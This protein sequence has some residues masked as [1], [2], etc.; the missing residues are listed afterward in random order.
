M[1]GQFKV[2][3]RVRALTDA[4]VPE[5]LWCEPDPTA[6]GSPFFIMRRVGGLIPPDVLPYPFGGN[7]LYD[8]DP[9]DQRR[10]QDGTV[11]ALAALHRIDSAPQRFSFLERDR[12]GDSYLQRHVAQTR[13]WYQ[14]VAADAGPVPLLERGFDWLAR[15]W[16]AHEPPPALSWGDARI[17]NVI[18]RD[19]SPAALLDWEMSGLGP[20]ELDVAW[21]VFAH[22]VFQALAAA[23]GLDGM[24][25]FLR[26]E[27]VCARYEQLTGHT[28]R[29][30]DF[31]RGYA[32]LQWGIVFV[33]T[34]CRQAHFGEREL[35]DDPEEL[36]YNRDQLAQL[37]S[38]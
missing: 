14:L 18:Y 2:L 8:A 9:V 12:P 33:R 7:W 32:G 19:F 15:H 24:P 23:L 13:T 1:V 17:G 31:Y 38:T 3:E 30:L 36:I 4:P 21:L 22:E 27:D 11:D 6:L 10:L 20:P 16:P 29:D 28:P 35:P 25:E 5:P 37:F 34:G 26:A